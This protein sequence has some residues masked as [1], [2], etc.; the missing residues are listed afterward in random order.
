MSIGVV[1]I[2]SRYVIHLGTASSQNDSCLGDSFHARKLQIDNFTHF[3][4]LL[5]SF[6]KVSSRCYLSR[7]AHRIYVIS[8][9]Y[10]EMC[11]SEFYLRFSVWEGTSHT[12]GTPRIFEFN[13]HVIN[14]ASS[15]HHASVR[16][17]DDDVRR[18]VVVRTFEQGPVV[19]PIVKGL[20]VVHQVTELLCPFRVWEIPLQL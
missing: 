2:L 10:F 1:R 14:S 16:R 4:E 7:K 19:P 11:E 8:C 17:H 5:R 12:T 6:A 15:R 18:A 3:I 20:V 13:L 9:L